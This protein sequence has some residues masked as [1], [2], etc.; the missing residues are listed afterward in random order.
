MT[1][2]EDKN[3]RDKQELLASLSGLA[4]AESV[5]L[6]RS[7]LAKV[8]QPPSLAE[9]PGTAWVCLPAGKLRRL[10]EQG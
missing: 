3:P 10:L 2:T 4:D 1:K 9:L 6:Q 8:L 5:T 7:R